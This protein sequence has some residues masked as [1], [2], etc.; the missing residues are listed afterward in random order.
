MTVTMEIKKN[1]AHWR[2]SIWVNHGLIAD[3]FRICLRADEAEEFIARLQ[4]DEVTVVE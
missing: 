4:P 2:L 3:P 1:P